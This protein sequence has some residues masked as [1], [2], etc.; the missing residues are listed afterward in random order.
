MK[1]KNL[2]IRI[3]NKISENFFSNKN[4]RENT[5]M[6]FEISKKII[7]NNIE[8]NSIENAENY[9]LQEIFSNN[10][11]QELLENPEINFQF[12]SLFNKY[13]K[14][15]ENE[16]I[17]KENNSVKEYSNNNPENKNKNMK[18]LNLFLRKNNFSI[19]RNNREWPVY[20]I[21]NLKNNSFII[22]RYTKEVF[23]LYKEIEENLENLE[24]Y[25]KKYSYIPRENSWKKEEE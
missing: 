2:E 5:K 11:L 19:V 7:V 23:S 10:S 15:N 17:Q 3:E 24:N 21:Q 8:F 1:R 12:I 16:K 14:K 25:F 20:K 6:N 18:N 22:F 13:R 4:N 9:I